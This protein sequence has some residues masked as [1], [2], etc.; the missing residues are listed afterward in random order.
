MT[1]KDRKPRTGGRRPLYTTRIVLPLAPAMLESIDRV[2]AEREKRVDFI[3][4]A[5]VR[6]LAQRGSR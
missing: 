5:I 1:P 4:G 6:E 3:R 2:R